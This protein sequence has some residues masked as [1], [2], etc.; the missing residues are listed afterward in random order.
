M[1]RRSFAQLLTIGA[2]SL[3]LQQASAQANKDDAD[4]TPA[5]KSKQREAHPEPVNVADIRA[6]AEARQHQHEVRVGQRDLTSGFAGDRIGGEDLLFA[7]GPERQLR[8]GRGRQF[9]DVA[10]G[11]GVRNDPCRMSNV[12][13]PISN[14]QVSQRNAKN[15]STF[16]IEYSISIIP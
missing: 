9:P 4:A 16:D 14:V 12:E 6:L 2:G 10:V 1:D 8:V 5:P 3:G 13:R 7:A 15:T 11:P